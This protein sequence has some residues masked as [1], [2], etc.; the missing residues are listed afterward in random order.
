LPGHP[1]RESIDLGLIAPVKLREGF[2]I[3]AGRALQQDVVSFLCL[4]VRIS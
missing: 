3:A 2:F 1:Q 4:D